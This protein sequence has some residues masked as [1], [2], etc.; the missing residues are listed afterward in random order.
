MVQEARQPVQ[1]Q[2]MKLCTWAIGWRR[3]GADLKQ[4][5]RSVRG[6]HGAVRPL[7]HWMV[8]RA[9]VLASKDPPF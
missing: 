2:E 9:D 4:P 6:D 1:S 3:R 8:H 5:A 7:V